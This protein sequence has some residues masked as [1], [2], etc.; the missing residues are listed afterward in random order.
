MATSSLAWGGKG[1]GQS[2]PPS[3]D[4]T[5]QRRG[6]TFGHNDDD[7]RHDQQQRDRPVLK[8]VHRRQQLERIPA[9]ATSGYGLFVVAEDGIRVIM[10]DLI[11][12]YGRLVDRA[13]IEPLRALV[14]VQ[15]DG[16][17]SRMVPDGTNLADRVEA[18]ANPADVLHLVG[19]PP[20]MELTAGEAGRDRRGAGWPCR[21]EPSG[22]CWREYPEPWRMTPPRAARRTTSPARMGRS[23]PAFWAPGATAR[24]ADCAQLAHCCCARSSRRRRRCPSQSSVLFGCRPLYFIRTIDLP[25]TPRS[26]AL[27]SIHGGSAPAHTWV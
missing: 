9:P 25:L 10:P 12:H 19:L 7:E 8:Q 3:P 14:G 4:P 27:G 21:R 13:L 26:R 6:Q 11:G 2:P 22:P 16:I 23:S 15:S 18:G 17:P 5:P 24:C 1:Q 20:L